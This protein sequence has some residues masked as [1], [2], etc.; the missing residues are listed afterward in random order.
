MGFL[1]PIA[2]ARR[3]SLLIDCVQNVLYIHLA[4]GSN[5]RDMIHFWIKFYLF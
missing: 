3:E 2:L 4:G 1:I 5:I